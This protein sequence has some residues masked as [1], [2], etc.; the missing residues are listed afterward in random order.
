MITDEE[1]NYFA[2]E[3]NEEGAAYSSDI[4]SLGVMLYEMCAL[5]L[6]FSSSK[7]AIAE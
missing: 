6:P 3:L 2:P 5:K 7:G 1:L 4:W